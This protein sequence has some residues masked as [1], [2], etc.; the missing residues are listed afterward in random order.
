M[1][2]E[3][4]IAKAH[5]NISRVKGNDYAPTSDEIQ[6]EIECI[7]IDNAAN[8]FIDNYKEDLF[9]ARLTFKAGA[10]WALKQFKQ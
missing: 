3:K 10:K 9:T 7:L 4:I 1:T 2:H 5:K 8:E 6:Y